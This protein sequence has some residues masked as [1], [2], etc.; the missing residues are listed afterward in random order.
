MQRIFVECQ[1]QVDGLRVY[2]QILLGEISFVPAALV[3]RGFFSSRILCE[4]FLEIILVQD[5]I[6]LDIH[7]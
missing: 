7:T 1:C 4:E 2:I 5:F 3:F 6:I